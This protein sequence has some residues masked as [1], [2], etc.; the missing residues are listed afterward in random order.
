MD[1]Q[2][3]SL[4]DKLAEEESELKALENR[5]TLKFDQDSPIIPEQVETTDLTRNSNPEISPIIVAE[6]P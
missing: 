3:K 1:N 4:L 6:K 2:P 5:G